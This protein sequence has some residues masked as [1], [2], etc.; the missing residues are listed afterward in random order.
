VLYGNAMP[1]NDLWES[2]TDTVC[3]ILKF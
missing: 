1:L 3:D 2:H